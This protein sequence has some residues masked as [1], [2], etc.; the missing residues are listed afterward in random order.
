M[1]TVLEAKNIEKVYDTGGNKFAALKGINLQVKEGEFVGIMGPSGSGKSTLL[2]ILSK[3]TAPTHGK[4]TLRGRVASLLEVGTGFHAE[5]TGRENIYLSGIILGMKRWEIAQQFDEIVAFSDVEKFLDIP[6]KK[7]SSGMRLRLAFSVASR[8]NPEILLIDEVLAV[9]D[10]EFEKKCHQEIGKLKASGRTILFVSHSMVA[11]QKFSSKCLVLSKGKLE[12]IGSPRNAV[13]NY[14]MTKEGVRNS[15]VWDDA[16]C[17]Q[18]GVVKI[19]SVHIMDSN[20][21]IKPV[22]LNND[23][24][25]IVIDYEVVKGGERFSVMLWFYNEK[26][27][28]LFVSLDTTNDE[29][30]YRTREKGCF[31]SVCEIPPYFFSAGLIYMTLK[32]VSVKAGLDFVLTETVSFH[33]ADIYEKKIIGDWIWEWPHTMV[34]PS[35]AWKVSQIE[36]K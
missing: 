21:N 24:I 5:L 17:P 4:V 18:D 28:L 22:F 2:K 11:I 1:K 26:G 25:T 35:V 8:L 32:V 27:D 10:Y 16:N 12:F 7:Y 36:G 31:Q 34:S 3:I 33:V 15:V 9:G 29:W 13:A 19:R 30:C 20:K 23:Q 14:L 6:V